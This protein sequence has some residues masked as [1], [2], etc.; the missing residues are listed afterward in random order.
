MI[1]EILI[2]GAAAPQGSKTPWGSEANPRTRPWRG[3]VAKAGA[4]AMHE[5]GLLASALSMEVVFVHARPKSHFG[6]GKNA[7][8]LK[9][10]APLYVTS[11]PDVD[12]LVRAISDAL[13]GV[14]YR[15][16]SQLAVVIARKIYGRSAFCQV[17]IRELPQPTPVDLPT[18]RERLLEACGGD[19]EQAHHV[20]MVTGGTT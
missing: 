17:L 4:E 15:N 6:T 14:V 10:S 3:A 13:Q 19:E 7:Q 12:K 5:R 2:H 1:V 16:D 20:E 18:R 9:P 11:P 8:R